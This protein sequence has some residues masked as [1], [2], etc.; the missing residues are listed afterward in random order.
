M[1]SSDWRCQLSRT[2]ALNG[3]VHL[4]EL[5]PTRRNAAFAHINV[6]DN[7]FTYALYPVGILL[8]ICLLAYTVFSRKPFYAPST[9]IANLITLNLYLANYVSRS[10]EG[11]H[12]PLSAS[13]PLMCQL[14]S[15]A[16]RLSTSSA[17][18]FLVALVSDFETMLGRRR[19]M[20]VTYWSKWS[21]MLVFFVPLIAFYSID[22][23]FVEMV[24]IPISLSTSLDIDGLRFTLFY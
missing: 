13:S 18:W 11:G 9:A 12:S 6:I 15:F 20:A 19:V 16:F 24:K 8:N 21:S 14:H 10:E 1:N 22:L 7:T 5:G 4:T 3:F 23:I 17:S 2:Q